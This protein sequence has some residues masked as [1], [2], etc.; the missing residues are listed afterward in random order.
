[1]VLTKFNGTGVGLGFGV[2][3]GFGVGWGF[4]GIPLQI[5]GLGVG[6][7]CGVGLGLGWGFGTA[8]GS[9]Y[10]TNRITFQGIDFN[11]KG[12]N[13]GKTMKD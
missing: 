3:C 10:R 13:D 11:D 8:L 9:Q 2:G 6:G 1:M 4:G 5:L 7:G 12:R